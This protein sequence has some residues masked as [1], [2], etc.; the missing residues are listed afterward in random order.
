MPDANR[1]LTA[2]GIATLLFLAAP[3]AFA[4]STQGDSLALPLR[5][6]LGDG[7]TLEATSISPWPGDF[8]QVVDSAGHIQYIAKHKVARIVDAKDRD[9]T[10]R[11]LNGRETLRRGSLAETARRPASGLSGFVAQGAYMIRLGKQREYTD[12]GHLNFEDVNRRVFQAEVGGMSRIG[13]KWGG[14]ATVFL[15]GNDDLTVLGIKARVRRVVGSK[16]YVDI[17]PGFISE[18]PTNGSYSNTKGFVGEVAVMADGIFGA[19]I[20]V[21]AADRPDASGR[22]STEWWWYLG[23]KFG[24]VPGIVAAGVAILLTMASQIPST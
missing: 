19:T 17:A 16:L 13:E 22:K 1:F 7:T 14:G 21:Q 11:A 3:A 12:V 5:V 10:T 2:V 4:D 20:Q 23:P 8:L 15:G 24:G 9:L 6:V 18:V